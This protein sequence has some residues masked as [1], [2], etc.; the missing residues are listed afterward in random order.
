M[1]DTVINYGQTKEQV[2]LRLAEV[3]A[4]AEGHTLG[5]LGGTATR[6][7]ILSTYRQCWLC[8]IGSEWKEKGK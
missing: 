3:V 5:S 1:A 4:R 7:Y 8:V 2:A 6:D